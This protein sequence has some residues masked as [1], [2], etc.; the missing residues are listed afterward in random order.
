VV[1]PDSLKTV[2]AIPVAAARLVA[3]NRANSLAFA[4][5]SAGGPTRLTAKMDMCMIDAGSG[6][7]L[8]RMGTERFTAAS[9]ERPSM[10]PRGMRMSPDGKYLYLGTTK[11]ERF[12]VDG[13]D[14]VYEEATR[15]L[16]A[17][18]SSTHIVLSDDGKWIAM[19]CES[20]NGQGYTIAIFPATN[21]GREQTLLDNG[22]HPRA[23]GFDPKTENIYSPNL[24][25][26]NVFGPRGQ[27]LCDIALTDK[28]VRRIVVDPRGGRFLAWCETTITCYRSRGD[29]KPAP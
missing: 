4:M 19:P 23:V 15:N 16:G 11:I 17:V 24:L 8:H 10:R 3:G 21:L 25:G 9:G 1:D 22:A 27:K 26:M 28:G 20:G 29:E 13:S 14:L 5:T 12:R 7:V 2:L 18:G 6:M